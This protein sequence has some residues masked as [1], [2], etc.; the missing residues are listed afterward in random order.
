[1]KTIVDPHWRRAN[2]MVRAFGCINGKLCCSS[3]PQPLSPKATWFPV[4]ATTMRFW[5][6]DG[7]NVVREEIR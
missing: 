2:G 1:M 7:V 3:D 5:I 6:I 4:Y